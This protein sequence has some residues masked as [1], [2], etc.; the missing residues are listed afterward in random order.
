[1]GEEGGAGEVVVEVKVFERSG[2]ESQIALREG[3]G[4]CCESGLERLCER[5]IARDIARGY[6]ARRREGRG[7]RGHYRNVRTEAEL[8]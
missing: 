8:A 4:R 1:M 7:T 5:D 6:S 2:R 3:G